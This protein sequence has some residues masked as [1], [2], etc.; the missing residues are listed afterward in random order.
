VVASIDN[1]NDNDNDD[2][3]N[4][5]N[6]GRLTRSLHT[7]VFPRTMNKALEKRKSPIPRTMFHM[8]TL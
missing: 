1:D 8:L 7:M 4:S 2:N 3:N 6:H 5:N